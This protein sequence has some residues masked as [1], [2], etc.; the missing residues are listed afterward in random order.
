VP[1]LAVDALAAGC[2]AP[3]VAV[4]A[5]LVRPIRSDIEEE[6]PVLL[7]RLGLALPSPTAARKVV[8]DDLARRIADGSL[9]AVEGASAIWVQ[10]VEVL[11]YD[12]Q[13]QV[14]PFVDL[15]D[16]WHGTEGAAEVEARIVGA[17]RRFVAGG[18]L[19]VDSID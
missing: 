18:G 13:D 7:R 4:F 6:L 8:I 15:I 12:F 2:E 3:E 14:L 10:W 19:R 9:P 17:A 5:S 1:E 11:N 16:E